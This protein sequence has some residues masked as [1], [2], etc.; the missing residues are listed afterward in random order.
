[1]RA[2]AQAK[3]NKELVGVSGPGS[4]T[5]GPGTIASRKSEA[6]RNAHAQCGRTRV[7]S[8]TRWPDYV[9]LRRLILLRSAPMSVTVA[10]DRRGCCKHKEKYRPAGPENEKEAHTCACLARSHLERSA[11]HV[12]SHKSERC[13]DII[14]ESER[15]LY[16][17]VVCVHNALLHLPLRIRG[18]E[19][20]KRETTQFRPNKAIHSPFREPFN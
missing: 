17:I 20:F 5:A 14:Q 1:M 11:W 18:S 13:S 6:G 7:C 4:F 9:R 16:S 8:G 3:A 10:F 2:T 19:V 15:K 12:V